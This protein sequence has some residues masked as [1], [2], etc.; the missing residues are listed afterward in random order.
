MKKIIILLTIILLAFTISC[1]GKE[2]K[3][4]TI[5]DLIA[6]FKSKGLNVGEKVKSPLPWLEL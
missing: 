4:K 2:N 6:H 5:D 1:Q 3:D